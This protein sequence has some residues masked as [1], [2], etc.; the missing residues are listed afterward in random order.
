MSNIRLEVGPDG[1]PENDLAGLRNQVRMIKRAALQGDVR[2]TALQ[3]DALLDDLHSPTVRFEWASAK[4]RAAAAERNRENM[5]QAALEK[6][7]M[8]D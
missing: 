5:A 7:A 4:E 2:E 3:L 6:P 1:K 8:F